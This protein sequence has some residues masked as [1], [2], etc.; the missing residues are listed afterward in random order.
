MTY[1]S[2]RELIPTIIQ[3]G[4]RYDKARTIRTNYKSVQ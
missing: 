4:E 2:N 1:L 3:T